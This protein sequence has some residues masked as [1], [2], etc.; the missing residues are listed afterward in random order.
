MDN[1]FAII[2]ARL[3]VIEELLID[4]KHARP[5]PDADDH[6]PPASG[7]VLGIEQ[8]CQYVPTLKR[9]TVYKLTAAGEIPHSKRGKRLYFDR[10]AIDLWLLSGTRADAERKAD[11]FLMNAT[12]RAG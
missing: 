10:D 8:L 6:R 9:S 5:A 4:I 1:P 3:S 12:R 11:E 7:K 2:D